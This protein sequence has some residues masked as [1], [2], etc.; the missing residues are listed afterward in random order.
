M[1]TEPLF[2]KRAPE[3]HSKA[4]AVQAFPGCPPRRCDRARSARRL[5][6]PDR[7]PWRFQS[8]SNTW[9][10]PEP[11]FGIRKQ[12]GFAAQWK[13]FWSNK[14]GHIFKQQFMINWRPS[15]LCQDSSRLATVTSTLLL[16][17]ESAPLLQ[18]R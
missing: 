5:R 16:P 3:A 12:P 10:W 6:V 17:I 8:T 18:N 2:L 11:L 15:P 7:L 13:V 4:A 9:H 14:S 1:R